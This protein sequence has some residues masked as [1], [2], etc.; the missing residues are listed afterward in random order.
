MVTLSIQVSELDI[1]LDRELS[2]VAVNRQV[3]VAFS[4]P[5]ARLDP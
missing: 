2:A 3:P 5:T 1:Y 4:T